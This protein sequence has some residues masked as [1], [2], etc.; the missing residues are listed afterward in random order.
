MRLIFDNSLQ[1]L[2]FAAPLTAYRQYIKEMNRFVWSRIIRAVFHLHYNVKQTGFEVM[3]SGRKHLVMPNHTAYIDPLII[4][5][6]CWDIPLRPFSDERF[7]NHWLF[8]HFLRKGNAFCVPDLARTKD[9]AAAIEQT[10]K[11]SASALNALHN[12]DEL[13]FYPSGHVKLTDQEIIGNRRLAYEVCRQ[14]PEGVQVVLV[15]MRG[16][17]KSRFSNLKEKDHPLRRNITI[18]YEDMTKQVCDWAQTMDRR[19][20]NEQLEKWYNDNE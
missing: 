8:G 17:E 15:R 12:G 4:I 9:R 16:L 7:I 14:L 3:H 2:L 13:I 1:T 6:E 5:S 10:A 18:H 20:F 11:L 19:S